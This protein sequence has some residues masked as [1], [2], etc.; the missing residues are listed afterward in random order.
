MSATSPGSR[1]T[2]PQTL[3]T[4]V[5]ASA[6][7]LLV[8]LGLLALLAP[9]LLHGQASSI[10]VDALQQ[11]V[12]GK[13]WLGTDNLGRDVLARVLVA[14]RLS[15]ELAT[16]AALL[17]TVAGV[18]LGGLPSILGRR[19]GRLVVAFIDLMVAFPGLLLALF[20][21][22]VFGVGARGAVLAIGIALMPGF[23][24]LTHTLAASVA[25]S[26]YVAGARILGVRRT[27]LLLRHV[28]PN[29]AEPLIINATIAVGVSLLS[30]AGLSF[31]GFGV[32][33]PDYDWGRMLNEGLSRI[34]V[35]PAAALAPGVA[36][37][38]AGIAFNLAGDAAAR[39]LGDRGRSSR[40]RP[41]G[42][43]D[44][45]APDAQIDATLSPAPVL[46]VRNLSV[47]FP[48]A[49]GDTSPVLDL[50]FSIARGEIL[51][52]VGESGSGKSLTAAAIADLV[53]HPGVIDADEIELLGHDVRA[54]SAAARNELL[55]RSVAVV[56]QDPMSA[57]NPALR[58]GRQLAEVAEVRDG[59]GR[60]DAFDRAVQRLR[61]VRIPAP[62]RRARQ[63][64]HEFSGGMRQ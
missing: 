33:A 57:L 18:L 28:L 34:Y 25:G 32:Q 55:G 4:P 3:R 38:I 45:P 7:L 14:T 58:V 62:E 23:A 47:R 48:V 2:V 22:V 31:L 1:W 61:A 35:N 43:R 39:T 6:A 37:V 17:G 64:P 60:R 8:L 9:I 27:R 15:L 42:P 16:M 11:G 20:L 50:N 44:E 26:D 51:G 40:R 54:L 59:A 41:V 36:V 52:V 24:R 21:A 5:G 49:A 63:Y 13:H 12:S 29:I 53:P 56:F 46:R 19:L 30:F 10:D